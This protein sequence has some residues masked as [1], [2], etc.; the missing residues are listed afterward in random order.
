[1]NAIASAQ[2]AAMTCTAAS[3][4]N[5]FD[6]F[7]LNGNV[8]CFDYLDKAA[9]GDEE[10]KQEVLLQFIRQVPSSMEKMEKAIPQKDSSTIKRIL[11]EL[12]TTVYVMGFG[13]LV[14]PTMKKMD[15]LVS[16]PYDNRLVYTLF[17]YIRVT[18]DAAVEEARLYVSH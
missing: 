9:Q 2:Y 10:F 4:E 5:H 17:Q 18:C 12:K 14:M 16:A 15:A 3:T 13:N 7:G 6:I 1:M 8:L 11:H